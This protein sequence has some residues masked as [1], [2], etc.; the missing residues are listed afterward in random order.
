MNSEKEG[1][2]EI[3]RKLKYM[4]IERLE[5]E[6]I[7]PEE[8]P[9]DSP[10]FGEGLG[11]DSLAALDLVILLEKEFNVK[12]TNPAQAREI[13]STISTLTEYILAYG[14]VKTTVENNPG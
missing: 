2:A 3:A 5:L 1:K 11:L 13:L 7:K 6:D 8:V 9:D 10:I 14:C 12:I 4:I